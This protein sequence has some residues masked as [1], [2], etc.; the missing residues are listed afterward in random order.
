[1]SFFTNCSLGVLLIETHIAFD[2][3]NKLLNVPTISFYIGPVRGK[4]GATRQREYK[5]LE[6]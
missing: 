1:M 5:E 6:S 4:C 3:V 2:F